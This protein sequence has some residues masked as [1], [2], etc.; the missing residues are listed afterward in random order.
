MQEHLF[1]V[2]YIVKENIDTVRCNLADCFAKMN[3]LIVENMIETKLVLAP[4]DFIITTGE[5]N[6][7]TSLKK[8]ECT[9]FC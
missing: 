7:F 6:Y 3:L 2:S 4:V 8:F 5:C 9:F 1:Y